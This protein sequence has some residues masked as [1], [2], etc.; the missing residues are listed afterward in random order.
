MSELFEL[1]EDFELLELLELFEEAFDFE[2]FEE[3]EL[4]FEALED[5]ADD[6]FFFE[7]FSL[8][9]DAFD[10]DEE[11]E[12]FLPAFSFLAAESALFD[13]LTPSEDLLFS[14]TE[15]A[16]VSAALEASFVSEALLPPEAQEQDAI[17]TAINALTPAI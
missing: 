17:K 7:L 12:L 10:S 8:F 2:L 13:S 16:E 5:L 6:E 11:P 9:A 14:E 15:E 1:F 4:D 3:S